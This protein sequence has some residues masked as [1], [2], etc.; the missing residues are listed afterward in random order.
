MNQAR[1]RTTAAAA[2]AVVL[3]TAGGLLT[4]VITPASA[5]TTCT[6]PVFKR[7]F[8]ANTGFSGTPKKTDCDSTVNENWGTGA[9]A[10]GLPRDN[11]SVRWTLT[12]DFGSGGPFAFTVSTQDGIRVYLDGTRKVDVWK[13]VSTTQRKT[14]NVTILSGKHTL[15]V[16]YVN[17]TGTANVSFSYTPRTSATVDKV[18]PL[19]P[20]GATWKSQTGTGN[21]T[22]AVLSWAANKEMD[23]AGYRVYRQAAGTGTWARVGTTTGRTFSNTPP[24][25]GQSYLYQVRAYDKAGNES[26][27][28]AALGPLTTPDFVAPAAPVLT[29]TSTADANDLSW[30][31]PADAVS[32]QVFRKKTSDPDTEWKE[33]PETTGTSWS[34]TSA[35][36]GISYDY[37]VLAHDAAWNHTF[38]AVVSGRPTITPPQNV[39]ATTP[40]YGAVISWTEPS[41]DDT[42][43]YTVLRSPAPADGTRTW[44]TADC[45]SRTTTTDE[46]GATV[47]SCTDYDGD[48][49]VTYAYAVR[50]K[51]SY[52]RWSVAS[53]E[54]LVTRPGDEI[55]PPAVTGLTAEPLEYGIRLDWDPSPAADL[56]KYLVYEQP[57]RWATPQL[58]GSVDGTRSDALLRTPADGEQKRYVVVAVDVYDNAATFESEDWTSPV[59]TVEVTERDL[60]PSTVPE[61][62]ACDLDVIALASGDVQVDPFCSGSRF[63]ETDGYHVYRWDPRTGSWVRLTETPVTTSY[64]IDTAAPA[65]TTVYYLVSFTEADG[66][67]AFSNADD[68]VTL[69][70]AP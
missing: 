38:S 10:S 60:S 13:N 57:T 28:S 11:F 39:T 63:T 22:T 48:R 6:S 62:T 31:A 4:T 41:G 26:V 42:T 59:A 69:P 70:S 23:L 68:A 27:G 64:W 16:D 32:F 47:H 7:Q 17:W 19:A 1:R 66:T 49:G 55:A 45:R 44:T 15:R 29:V 5:A 67:E 35:V 18:R 43:G 40:S 51:D 56:A 25:T 3:A 12:R 61:N 8:F 2:T 34:D 52:D 58:V 46:S 24:Q 21:S 14:V 33:Y 53:P 36:Y 65:G 9:P 30:T 54:V 20:T 50:R 37:K